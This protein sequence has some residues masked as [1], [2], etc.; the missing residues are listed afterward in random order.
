MRRLEDDET[1]TC[2]SKQVDHDE[3]VGDAPTAAAGRLLP[4]RERRLFAW[5]AGIPRPTAHRALGPAEVPLFAARCLASCAGRFGCRSLARLG[6][7]SDA[8]RYVGCARECF[9]RPGL[10]LTAGMLRGR[11][12]AACELLR[13]EDGAL[14][15]AESGVDAAALI[16]RELVRGGRS[17]L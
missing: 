9:G 16:G 17:S 2:P 14:R 6:L 11:V 5:A 4:E 8:G 13:V 12:T 7:L 1:E 15:G 10:L 3:A